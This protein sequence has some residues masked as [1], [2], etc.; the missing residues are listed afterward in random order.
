MQR[1]GTAAYRRAMEVALTAAFTAVMAV[2]LLI[3]SLRTRAREQPLQAD[4]LLLESSE[5]YL[6]PRPV[7]EAPK[8]DAPPLL[9]EPEALPWRDDF[10][11]LDAWRQW[12]GPRPQIRAGM[13][14]FVAQPD[15]YPVIYT[16]APLLIG[17]AD[18]EVRVRCNGGLFEMGIARSLG[19]P[20]LELGG[21]L[22]NTR[23]RDGLYIYLN[24]RDL[25]Q[26]AGVDVLA[27][28]L[29]QLQTQGPSPRA[30]PPEF[31][32]LRLSLRRQSFELTVDGQECVADRLQWSE[33]PCVIYLGSEWGESWVDYIQVTPAQ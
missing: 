16:R 7:P 30:T 5:D 26:V 14:G 20:W 24:R 18:I 1:P 17:E 3:P 21:R 22:N 29:L 4:P 25:P 12:R 31:S 19:T 9:V 15:Y 27:G 2:L 13:L 33:T 6:D 10:D 8:P 32:T 28:D 11:S 23:V